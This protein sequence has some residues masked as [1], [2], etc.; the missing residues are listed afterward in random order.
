MNSIQAN[1]TGRRG[2]STVESVDPDELLSQSE[3]ATLLRQKPQTLAGWRCEGKGPEYVKV[4][5]SVYYRRTAISTWL[6]G[7]IVRPSAA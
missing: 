6:A 4:G 1:I 3:V 7:Q 2:G 5:R